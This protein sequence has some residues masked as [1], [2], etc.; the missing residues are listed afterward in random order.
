MER[1]P[2]DSIMRDMMG[3]D[4]AEGAWYDDVE[5][6]TQLLE[7]SDIEIVTAQ[8]IMADARN[9]R[10]LEALVKALDNL[11]TIASLREISME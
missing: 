7:R 1:V 3:Q 10:E 6:W 4:E 11:E 2:F 5:F 8:Q 9:F